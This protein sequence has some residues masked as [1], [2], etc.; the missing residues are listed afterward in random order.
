MQAA[1]GAAPCESFSTTEHTSTVPSRAMS[2]RAE[3]PQNRRRP[4]RPAGRGRP[5]RPK[6]LSLVAPDRVVTRSTRKGR[7]SS[8]VL[9]ASRSFVPQVRPDAVTV[10]CLG[11]VLAHRT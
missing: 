4:R 11:Q 6:G 3:A 10:V 8:L 2:A 9:R 5:R 1:Q 7:H